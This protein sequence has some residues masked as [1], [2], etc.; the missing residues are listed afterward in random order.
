VT[1][2]VGELAGT[3]HP[4]K[5]KAP[6]GTVIGGSYD[7]ISA[8]TIACALYS[9]VQQY[10]VDFAG[11]HQIVVYD[12]TDTA[13]A[14]IGKNPDAPTE[15]LPTGPAPPVLTMLQPDSAGNWNVE[16]HALGT[17]FGPD[18][19]AVSGEMVAVTTYISPTEVSFVVPGVL[20]AGVYPVKIRSGGQDSNE[21]PFTAL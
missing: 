11:G 5:V 13:I 17:G 20:A 4:Y 2:H 9:T 21:L 12:S 8:V 3:V 6:D 7:A 18:A 19:V 15:T 16:V 1:E 14:A 10:S